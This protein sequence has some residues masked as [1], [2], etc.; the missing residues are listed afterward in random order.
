MAL[1][2]AD[3]ETCHRALDYPGLVEAMRVAHSGDRP[4]MKSTLVDS[5]EAD[6]NRFITL[7]GWN[8]EAIA[9]KTI[10]VFPSNLSRS[11]PEPSVQG[12]VSVYSPETGTPLLV[13]D[14]S[15]ITQRKTAADS[16]LGSL[17]LARRDA[18]TLLV[19]GAGG[20]G[21]HFCMVHKAVR[22]SISRIL[23]WN[24]TRSRAE[25]LVEGLDMPGVRLE[26]ADDL[27]AAVAEADII[28]CITMAESPLVKGALLKPGAHLDLVG[29]YLPHMREADDDCIR[30]ARLFV[31]MRRTDTGAGELLDPIGRG[32][33]GWDDIAGDLFE[34]CSGRAEGRRSEDE[35]TWFKN[36]GGGH[37]DMFTAVHLHRRLAGQKKD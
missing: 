33:M 7:L 1:H 9:V 37:L 10:G 34:L 8:T 4:L 23:V 22:P 17:L 11:P 5:P 21:P 12:L 19:V 16:G 24:R 26:V 13:C 25:A 3:A 29:S 2:F 32:V 35:I 20:L 27:D 31:D 28:S 15:A 6:G 18:E 14:G 30:R 36:M